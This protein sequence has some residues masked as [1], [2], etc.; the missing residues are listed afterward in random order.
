M[1]KN[2]FF[3]FISI[4]LLSAIFPYQFTESSFSDSP[5][6]FDKEFILDPVIDIDIILADYVE[7][8]NLTDVIENFLPKTIIVDVGTNLVYYIDYTF[9]FADTAYSNSLNS[10]V[11]SIS[12]ISAETA[13]LNM[14]A[15][16]QQRVDYQT[17][18]IFVPQPGTAIDGVSLE[19]YLWDQTSSIAS[20]S[21]SYQLYLLNF[22]RFD[23]NNNNDKHWFEIPEIDAGSNLQRTWWR[24][25]WDI[26]PEST[27]KNVNNYDAKFP[28]PGYSSIHPIYFLDP[29]AHQWY[30]NWTRLWRS[31]PDNEAHKFYSQTLGTYIESLGGLSGNIAPVGSYIGYW[32]NEI[33]RN[34]FFYQPIAEPVFPD[35]LTVQAAIFT[36]ETSSNDYPELDWIINSTLIIEELEQLLP[37]ADVQME[38]SIQRLENHSAVNTVLANNQILPFQAGNAP[39]PNY[40]YYYG[41]GL[42][43]D[44]QNLDNLYF[45]NP[46][47]E[48]IIRAYVFILNDASLCCAGW[49]GGGLY[50]G[51]G[52][53]GRI[54][55]LN[56]VDR[57]MFN[58]TTEPVPKDSLSKVF[59]HEAGHA[60]GLPHTFDPAIS[61][62]FASDFVG[63]VMGYY[64][65]TY[66]YSSLFIKGYQ[67]Y[68]IDRQLSG[69][70]N[71]LNYK[72][73]VAPPLY[74]EE[75]YKVYEE[76]MDA[77]KHLNFDRVLLLMDELQD[78]ELDLT[79]ATEHSPIAP[80]FSSTPSSLVLSAGASGQTLSWT[81][82]DN[83]PYNYSLIKNGTEV[84]TGL[85]ESDSAITH[86]LNNLASGFWL[87]TLTVFDGYGLNVT[88]SVS[89]TVLEGGTSST[90]TNTSTIS[91]T[92][93]SDVSEYFS[94]E[95]FILVFGIMAILLKRKRTY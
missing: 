43:Y 81:A 19:Q 21:S 48:V 56:E 16:D 3:T 73:S 84:E 77:Y 24:L 80:S 7:D 10:F 52:G 14:T 75:A 9:I 58:R 78:W 69:I 87:F 57:L 53:S 49:G 50:T 51:L 38:Y 76:T 23:N 28:Y 60:I 71:D 63:E 33:V 83:S 82:V 54:M 67:R 35:S 12:D 8:T 46:N 47:S 13:T 45:S 6:T 32:I 66:H 27:F 89:V 22:S 37:N 17:E 34:L 86:S 29:Y 85:W 68:V 44:V 55:I 5:P 94:I 39:L 62:Q 11:D 95:M 15:L 26:P 59:V 1:R 65:G 40:K 64:P 2:V 92:G 70:L 91:N 90:S 74:L 93:T 25:E 61:Y 42:F 41:N 30:L 31:V 88:H 18:D 79:L 4:L 20:P 72:W 36:D